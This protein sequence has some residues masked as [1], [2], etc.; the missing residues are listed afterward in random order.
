MRTAQSIANGDNKHD[1]KGD[2]EEVEDGYDEG[3]EDVEY[4]DNEDQA[5]NSEE[6][7]DEGCSVDPEVKAQYTQLL[8]AT[9]SSK[10]SV[11]TL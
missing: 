2:D 3:A 7:E 4:T 11:C 8:K 1:P 10:V 9:K 6:E 5:S